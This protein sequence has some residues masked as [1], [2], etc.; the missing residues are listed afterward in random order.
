MI[1]ILCPLSAWSV[2]I[3]SACIGLLWLATVPLTS[4]IVFGMFGPRYMATLYG[5]VFLSHQVGSFASAWLGGFIWDQTGSY[6]IAW[7]III[8]GGAL[9]SLLHW[10]IDDRPVE[11]VLKD[12]KN[13]V[14]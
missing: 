6:H 14:V 12:R 1:F 7:W 10:P 11:E 4:G 5:I 3:F 2:Y 9:A 8:I 13:I